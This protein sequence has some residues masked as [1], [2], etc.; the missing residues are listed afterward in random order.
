MSDA[1]TQALVKAAKLSCFVN[2]TKIEVLDGGMTNFNVCVYDERKK[3]VVRIGQDIEEHGV[4]RWNELVISQAAAAV[5]LSPQVVHSEKGVLVLE[6]LTAKT[7]T[8]TDVRSS[9]NFSRVIDLIVR[10]HLELPL[11]L[12][13]PVLAFWPFHINRLYV[14]RL[15]E[16]NS[17]YRALFQLMIKQL[18][19]L[20]SVVGPVNLVVAHNDLLAANILDTGGRL[21]LIDWEYGGVNSPL[22]DLAGLA[23]NNA[24]TEKHEV[25]ML[26]QYF[27]RPSDQYWRPYHA[28][29][30]ASLMREVLWSMTSEIYSSL[31]FDYRQYTQ[32]NLD[33][34][35]KAYAEFEQL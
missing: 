2:P 15:I 25:A 9:E 28:M 30:C 29:K 23:S 7:F 12:Q 5:G 27:N 8:A 1:E 33:R 18:Q 4:M 14:K 19:L 26:E 10:M 21:W 22:F 17:E 13:Q 24:F 11:K 3:Y 31:T 20:E 35:N 34:F 32:D 16:K 6:F